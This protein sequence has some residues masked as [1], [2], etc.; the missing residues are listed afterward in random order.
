LTVAKK[1]VIVSMPEYTRIVEALE[2][3]GYQDPEPEVGELSLNR[4][5]VLLNKRYIGIWDAVGKTF[6]D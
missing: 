1:G 5:E 4:Y 2:Q 6:V 3:L